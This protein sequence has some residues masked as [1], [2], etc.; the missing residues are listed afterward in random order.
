MINHAFVDS[1]ENDSPELSK[2]H[3]LISEGVC[4]V[5]INFR[6]QSRNSKLL[7]L[8]QVKSDIEQR[9][10]RIKELQLELDKANSRTEHLRSQ[11]ELLALTLQVS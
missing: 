4:K 9:D 3:Y 2:R 11:N 8:T 5:F 10:S 7:L 6:L 1:F